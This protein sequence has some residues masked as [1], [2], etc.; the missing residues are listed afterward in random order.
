[1]RLLFSLSAAVVLAVVT[2]AACNS[3]ETNGNRASSNAGSGGNSSVATPQ[4]SS[5]GHVAPSDGVKRVTTVEVREALSK[6]TAIVVDVRGDVPYKQ[7]HIKGS[8]SIPLEQVAARAKELPRD[9][10]IVTYCS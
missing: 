2:L 1:M 5:S 8:V 7:N 9:K 4:P 6:G 3:S 10:M